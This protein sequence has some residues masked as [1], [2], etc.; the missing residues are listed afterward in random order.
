MHIFGRHGGPRSAVDHIL[1]NSLM[2]KGFRRMSIDENAEEINISDHNMIRSWFKIR[3]GDTRR[4]ER[5]KI[6]IRKGF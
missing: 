4:W 1:V 6:E 3:R 5:K 2:E